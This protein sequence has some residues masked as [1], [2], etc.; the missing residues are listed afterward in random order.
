M[1][2]WFICTFFF[3]LSRRCWCWYHFGWHRA[4]ISRMSTL[5][6][7]ISCPSL[8][9]SPPFYFIL[10]Y[11]FPVGPPLSSLSLLHVFPKSKHTH[12]K[13][14]LEYVTNST[15]VCVCVWVYSKKITGRKK[16]KKTKKTKRIDKD[17]DDEWWIIFFFYFWFDNIF[18][19]RW[20]FWVCT[21]L[22]FF[23]FFSGEGEGVR[24]HVGSYHCCLFGVV[25]L[26]HTHTQIDNAQLTQKEKQ[27]KNIPTSKQESSMYLMSTVEATTARSSSAFFTFTFFVWF[28][29]A[30]SRS[31]A[32]RERKQEEHRM[33]SHVRA[34]VHVQ[35]INNRKQKKKPLPVSLSLSASTL[36]FVEAEEK[37]H[38]FTHTRSYAWGL[39]KGEAMGT[40]PGPVSWLY[41]T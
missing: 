14:S 39:E 27:K 29:K 4:F 10:F 26:Q 41:L 1:L 3:S 25:H 28:R 32:E 30:L 40:T 24:S 17:D 5:N 7:R 31:R 18:L 12:K 9:P 38:T 13:V 23:Y 2:K 34:H 16:K 6:R 11:F 8:P 20:K 19:C 35:I 21:D 22:D 15:C 33:V 37:T 36:Q